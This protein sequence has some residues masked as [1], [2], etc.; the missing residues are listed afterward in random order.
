M[1]PRLLE[2]AGAMD[3]REREDIRPGLRVDI[4][5]EQDQRTGR[6]PR[7]VV[8]E[9]LTNPLTTRTTSRRFGLAERDRQTTSL[10]VHVP[11]RQAADFFGACA[12]L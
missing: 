2:G 1:L 9:V 3:G 4:V 7:G 5:L 10:K 6:L 11:A 8:K 12:R